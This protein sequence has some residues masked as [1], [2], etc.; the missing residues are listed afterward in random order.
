MN[1]THRIT[2]VDS[3]RGFA[4]CGIILIH[5]M[6]HMN[7]YAFP[8]QAPFNQTIWDTVWFLGSSKMYAIFALL[9]GFSCF[10]QHHNQEVK[11][12]DFRPRFAWRMVLLFV[13]GLLDLMFYNG[14]ILG[15]YAAMGLLMIPLVKA[16][17][18][19]LKWIAIFLFLQP[20]ELI[21]MILGSLNPEL[22]PL[23]TGI[24]PLWGILYDACGNGSI[25]DVAKAGL[26]TGLQVNFG[27]AI[28]NGRLTQTLMLFII[29]FLLGRHGR[30]MDTEENTKFWKKVL[31]TSLVAFA[32]FLPLWKTIPGCIENKPVSASLET[33]L[34]QWRNFAM[35]CFYV[36]GITLLFYHTKAQKAI[37]QLSYIG[38]MSLTDYLIQSIVGGFIFYNWGLHLYDKTPHYAS[39]LIAVA[40]LFA[41]YFF[42]RWWTTHHKRGPLEEIWTRLTWIGGKR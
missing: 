31:V 28:E 30:F 27:W 17:D 29:G 2:V 35:T 39:L 23:N 36:S 5:F 33:L 18:K 37:L 9:F 4:V 13:W 22:H 26:Q 6:E 21:Y 10:I 32:V 3:L 38:K 40:F 20:V 11:G 15:T 19:V 14:D 12:Y 41:L 1:S 8:E 24:G 16:P 42:C 34:Y 7:F 25:L